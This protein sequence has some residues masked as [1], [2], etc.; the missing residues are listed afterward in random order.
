MTTKPQNR[1]PLALLLVL[2]VA[3]VVSVC[4]DSA[5][6]AS[7]GDKLALAFAAGPAFPLGR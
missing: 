7:G 2:A 3:V 6:G 1:T 4:G 5:G